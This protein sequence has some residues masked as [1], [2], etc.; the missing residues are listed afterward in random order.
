MRGFTYV[1]H[2]IWPVSIP[3]LITGSIIG[4]GEGWEALVAT[5]IIMSVPKGLGNFFD[6]NASHGEI[7]V[8]GILGLLIIIFS[9]NKL[10]WLPLLEASHHGMEE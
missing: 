8:L 6:T 3:G 1:R 9:I 4:L 7:T 2:F 5:E 10:L